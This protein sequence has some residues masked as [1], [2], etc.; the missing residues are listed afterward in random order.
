[1][2]YS[3][4]RLAYFKL[5]IFLEHQQVL[6][7]LGTLN[8]LAWTDHVNKANYDGGWDVVA[9]R[10][11]SE[12]LS[13]HPILQNFAIE[14]GT[15][16]Q[17]LPILE[18]KPLLKSFVDNFP[19]EVL[20]VRIMRLKAGAFIKPHRD[21]GL[22]IENGEARLHIPLVI[23]TAL[24]FVVDGMQVPMKEGE[25]WYINAD[26]I[27]SVANRGNLDRVNIVID[28]KVNDW[29]L[30]CQSGSMGVPCEEYTS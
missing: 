17:N 6:D 21:G 18:E 2:P 24:E 8:E 14:S 12:H 9:L 28:C 16:W 13:A 29:L 11:L 15:H 25:V 4:E 27:H 19:C 26:K 3:K 7:E 22:C 30:G 1:M 20:S 5:P 10:C 23:D